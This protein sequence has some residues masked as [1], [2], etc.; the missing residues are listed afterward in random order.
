[1]LKRNRLKIFKYFALLLAAVLMST[2]C[3]V[4]FHHH[5]HH[6]G[7]EDS[8]AICFAGQVLAAA[9]HAPAPVKLAKPVLVPV[10]RQF[11]QTAPFIQTICLNSLFIHG[12]PLA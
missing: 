1:M 8:C 5:D 12:P 6:E 2:V 9:N 3:V 10:F 11:C 4:A 7:A